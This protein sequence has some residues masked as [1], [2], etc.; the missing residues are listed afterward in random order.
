MAKRGF[1]LVPLAEI[2]PDLTVPGTGS[3][4]SDLL[5]SLDVPAS[6]IRK[7]SGPPPVA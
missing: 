5:S 7:V 3:T 4:V 6:E 1:V 2:A